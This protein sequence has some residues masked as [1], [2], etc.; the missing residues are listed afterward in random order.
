MRVVKTFLE[1]GKVPEQGFKSCASL[2]NMA[3]KYTFQRLEDACTRALSYTATPNIKTIR[4]IL[5]T[6]QDKVKKETPSNPS[7]GSSFA[8]TRGASYYQGGAH[9]D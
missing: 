1:S 6:G 9:N 8:F 3:D 2:T 7:G 4:M 5:Q